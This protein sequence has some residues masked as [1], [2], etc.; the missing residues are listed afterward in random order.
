MHGDERKQKLS[1]AFI[2]GCL[3]RFINPEKLDVTLPVR[4]G[5]G[6]IRIRRDGESREIREMNEEEYKEQRYEHQKQQLYY[7]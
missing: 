5:R 6:R 4:G 7:G 2:A 3:S 1:G